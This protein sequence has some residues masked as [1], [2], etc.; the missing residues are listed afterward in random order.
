MPDTATPRSYPCTVTEKLRYCDTDRQGHVNNAIFSTFCE[1]GR[2]P[3]LYDPSRGLPP[4]GTQ[5]VI[6]RLTLNFIE[7][8]NWPGEV[9]IGTGVARIGRSSLTLDQGIFFE[10]RVV[11]TADSVIVLMDEATRKSTPLPDEARKTFEA[12]MT[13]AANADS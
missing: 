11:G 13:T 12:L 6:A 4:P 5:F 2:V 1:S 3:F 7:E 8:I 9:E 10:G